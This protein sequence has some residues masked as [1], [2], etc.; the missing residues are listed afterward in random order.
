ADVA[1]NV[2]AESVQRASEL[3]AA[4][5]DVRVLGVLDRHHGILRD[6]LT[7]LVHAMLCDVHLPCE[8]HRLR[9]GAARSEA[10]RDQELVDARL[11]H[12]TFASGWTA[13]AM[14]ARPSAK[15]GPGRK[16][17]SSRTSKTR[18]SRTARSLCQPGVSL[19]IRR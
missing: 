15:R 18:P 10:P 9:A 11:R 3:D 8:Q 1:A 7:R 2:H 5:R 13:R 19:A 6:E 17:A 12:G 16:A 14:R 4:A